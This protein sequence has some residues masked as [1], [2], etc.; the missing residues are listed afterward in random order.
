MFKI[1]FKFKVCLKIALDHNLFVRSIFKVKIRTYK[2]FVSVLPRSSCFMW[3]SIEIELNSFQTV[4][5]L[6]KR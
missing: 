4:N 6:I 2:V 5:K 1:Q 3:N